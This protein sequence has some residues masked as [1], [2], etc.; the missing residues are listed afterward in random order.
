MLILRTNW[1][2]QQTSYGGRLIFGKYELQAFILLYVANTVMNNN[3]DE[4]D[5]N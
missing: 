1:Y 2:N 4:V 5:G 3:S